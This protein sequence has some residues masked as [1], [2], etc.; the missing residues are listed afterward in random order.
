MIAGINN[1]FH[2]C[3]A[4]IA[5]LYSIYVNYFMGLVCE[6]GNAYLIKTGSAFQLLLQHLHCMV[7]YLAGGR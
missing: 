7:D 4:A 3:Q 2:I 6:V 1:C 5:Y